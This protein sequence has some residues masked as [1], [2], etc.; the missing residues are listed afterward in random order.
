MKLAF[1]CAAAL[2]LTACANY[3]PP[4]PLPPPPPGPY[5]GLPPEPPPPG[6]YLTGADCFRTS[7][8][9]N[10]TIGDARTLYLRVGRGE[11]YRVG[12]S[13]A[14]LAG[15]IDSDPLV[16]R[17]PPGSPIVCRPL[18]LDVGVSKGGFE[19]P[20]I[21]GSIVRLTPAEADALPRKLKP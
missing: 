6:A 4:E 1:V 19:S 8:I 5:V 3:Y 11:V 7:D 9:R 18:D 2:S 16:M 17:Q 12:M 20:C 15:A 13:G 10:H 21:V 14:C